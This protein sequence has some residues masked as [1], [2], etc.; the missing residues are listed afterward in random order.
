MMRK[1]FIIAGCLLIFFT[2][3]QLK[4]QE[5]PFLWLE[6]IE[7]KKALEWVDQH[8]KKSVAKLESVPGF[9]KI[10]DQVLEI[11]N[12]DERI[13]KA[14][15]RGDYLYNFWRDAQH[16]RGLYRRTT[17]EEYRKKNPRWETILDIDALAKEEG[18]NW[19]Y[20]GMN[21][22]YPE[23]NRCLVSLSRGG[24]DATVVREL[25]IPSKSFVKDG[26]QLPE[27]KSLVSWQDINTI[28]VA[29]DF[30]EG[31]LTTSGYP[32][33]VKLW[34]R[35]T[36]PGNAKTV[37]QAQKTS[38]YTGGFRFFSEQ[39]HLDLVVDRKTFFKQDAYLLEDGKLHKV[40]IPEDAELIGYFKKQ[41]LVRLKSD[42]NTGD[43][44]Y[45]QG[46]VIIGKLEDIMVGKKEFHVLMEPGE[47]RSISSVNTTKSMILITVLD[48]VVSKLYQ[49]T[50]ED[51]GQWRQKEIKIADNGTL[52][53][54]NTNEK[55]DDY[56]IIYE[57]FLTPDSL[58]MISGKD[59]KFEK[60]K[61][62]PGF[63]DAGSYKTRQFEAVSKDGTRIPYF[64]VMKKD[65][66]LNGKN[67]T[68][69]YGYGGFEVSLKPFYSAT[70]GCCWLEKGGVFVSANIRGGGEFGPKWHQAGLLKNRHKV[71]EDF[72]AVAEDLIKRK[73]T[74]PDKLA[75]QGGSNG[76]LLV[77]VI[78]T[79]RPDLFKAVLCQ[80]PLLDM[81]RYTKMPPGASWMAEYG[82]PDDPDMWEYIK[83]YSPYHNLKKNVK[84]PEIFFSTSTRDDRVHP[85]HARKMAAK[86]EDMGYKVF[87][88]ENTEGGHA[89]A[90]NN[91]Q[92]AYMNALNY[93]FLYIQLMGK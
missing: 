34:K 69:L 16:L 47:R 77:G 53:V 55:S 73:I 57:N 61:S 30:G 81:Q 93:T 1:S 75:I 84:Y 60:L 7:G 62:L 21:H 24:A 13:P 37:F 66:K 36:P 2:G 39:G 9:K 10:N 19:V 90:A 27:A 14:S 85:G 72:I 45:Q 64:V 92:R 78:F 59:G 83:T 58:Y 82:D 56:F 6:E 54:F 18:E 22:L 43:K 65:I 68:L 51:T 35:G 44:T 29:T 28:F 91:K 67:P 87:Y 40:D 11:L 23:Y 48:N 80:A 50:Q 76:G 15:K 38:V 3:F 70:V 17:L 25:D 74:S 32:A 89:G 5:D 8:N 88:Y 20:K 52:S 31:S 79:M 42:W 33:V 86:M 63:F 12:S 4:A 26:F 71:Y 46:S 41:V 49:F